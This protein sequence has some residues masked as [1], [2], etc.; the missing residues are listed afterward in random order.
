[1]ASSGQRSSQFNCFNHFDYPNNFEAL[2]NFDKIDILHG[3]DTRGP[4][5][6]MLAYLGEMRLCLDPTL[7]QRLSYHKSATF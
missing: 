6:G 3:S 5:A 7:P 2:A 1:M 4:S